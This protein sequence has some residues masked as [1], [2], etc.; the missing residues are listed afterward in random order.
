MGKA[1]GLRRSL[2]FRAGIGGSL[3]KSYKFSSWVYYGDE[4]GM[5]SN[6]DQHN[7]ENHY[8]QIGDNNIDIWYRQP[9]LWADSTRTHYKSGQFKFELDS[10]NSTLK[11]VD[12]QKADPNSMYN[13]YK[14]LIEIKKQY[15]K[16]AK[17]EYKHSSGNVLGLHVYGQGKELW[18]YINTGRDASQYLMDPGAGFT[19]IKTMGNAPS[20]LG[21][22]IGAVKWS[23]SAFKK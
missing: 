7:D 13:W 12:Q 1:G 14:D 19:N 21:G 22:D 6:T 3:T 16:G 23:V 10:Y 20:N 11:N 9:F 2:F 5:S 4:L 15:P 8:P 17:L 18:I